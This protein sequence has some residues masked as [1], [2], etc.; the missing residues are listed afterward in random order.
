MK[1]IVFTDEELKNLKVFLGRSDLKGQEVPAFLAI[2]D[3]INKA[4]VVQDGEQVCEP[5]RGK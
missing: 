3:K 1:S 5:D 4:E 2:L